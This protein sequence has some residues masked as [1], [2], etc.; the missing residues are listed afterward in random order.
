VKRHRYRQGA[1]VGLLAL[2]AAACNQHAQMIAPD[3]EVDFSCHGQPRESVIESFAAARGFRP[4][5]EEHARRQLEQGFFPLEIDSYDLR[6]RMLD[7]IGLR[8]PPS[9]GNSVH[10][11]LTILGPPPTVHDHML[12]SAALGLVRNGLRCQIET[13]GTN[14]NDREASH[15]FDRIFVDQQRRIAE[16]APGRKTP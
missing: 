6:R 16:L 12:E 8:E 2:L 7:V 9:H 1:F 15:L 5:N 10:Y 11:R 4:F 14:D 13:I 3:F